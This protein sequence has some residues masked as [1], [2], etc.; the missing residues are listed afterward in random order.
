[1]DTDKAWEQWG[2]SDPYF[3]VLTDEKYRSH[4]L[5]KEAKAD[6]F[7]T[8]QDHVRHVLDVCRRHFDAAY[9][10][11]R[12]LDFGC[13]TGRLTIPFAEIAREVVGVDVSDS[14]LAEAGRNCAARGI[15]NAL[16]TKS[17]DD[18]ALV[19]GMF[20]LVHSFIV[21]QHIPT[22]RGIRLLE[23][24]LARLQAGGLAAVHLTY[25]KTSF[26]SSG[27]KSPLAGR[28]VA[29]TLQRL[30]RQVERTLRR[31]IRGNRYADPEM[32]MNFYD[33]NSL[34]F[35][36]Q[37]LGVREAFVEFTDHGGALG[38]MLYLRK[39]ASV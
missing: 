12:V 31:S 39:P 11:H 3:G 29:A 34:L 36:I 26:R 10:P 13:G 1:M 5:S 18:L 19:P 20:D 16:F 14:M 8:G 28:P 22:S 7:A 15:V 6:F 38:T 9:T 37:D 33:A 21:F 24:L 32:Q 27:G 35:R 23:L 4:N 30:G 25:S 2:R 17:S